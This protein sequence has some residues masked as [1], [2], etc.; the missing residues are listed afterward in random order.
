[1]DIDN[2]WAALYTQAVPKGSV[3][4]AGETQYEGYRRVTFAAYRGRA[5]QEVTFPRALASHPVPV[6]HLVIMDGTGKVL[7]CKSL[8]DLTTN[9]TH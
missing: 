9:V 6:T 3:N 5:L 1:M 8:K 4:P 7:D 2:Y